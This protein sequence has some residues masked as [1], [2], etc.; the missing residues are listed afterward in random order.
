MVFLVDDKI[1][2]FK[3]NTVSFYQL[4]KIVIGDVSDFDYDV[5]SG[6]VMRIFHADQHG[7]IVVEKPTLLDFEAKIK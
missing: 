2:F 6:D 4:R 5:I 1:I 7:R 3:L